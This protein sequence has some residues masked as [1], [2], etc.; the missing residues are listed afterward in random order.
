MDELWMDALMIEQ[1]A[2][3]K[4]YQEGLRHGEETGFEKG[5]QLGFRCGKT[6]HKNVHFYRGQSEALLH[7]LVD[8]HGPFAGLS[9][10]AKQRYIK[11]R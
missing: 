5:F 11:R 7:L 4:G 3:D 8:P 1:N 9:F 6:L 2:F 10:S